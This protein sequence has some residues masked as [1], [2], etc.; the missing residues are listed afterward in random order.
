MTKPICEGDCF[1]C[2]LP[3]CNCNREQLGRRTPF[4]REQ[5]VIRREKAA[6]ARAQEAH[7]KAVDRA[8]TDWKKRNGIRGYKYDEG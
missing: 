2:P 7:R 8:F 1:H 3:D 5:I 4:E 6:R